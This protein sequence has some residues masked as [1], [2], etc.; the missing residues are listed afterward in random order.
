LIRIVNLKKKKVILL[1]NIIYLTNLKNFFKVFVML[2]NV[3]R[4]KEFMKFLQSGEEK[5][6]IKNYVTTFSIDI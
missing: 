1:L 4:N 5:D 2:S 6:T 3:K